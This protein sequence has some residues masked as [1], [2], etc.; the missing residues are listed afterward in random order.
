VFAALALYVISCA[1]DVLWQDSGMIQYRVWRNDIEGKL[2][3]AL[4]HPLFYVLAIGAKYVPIGQFAHK[5]NLVS[6][7]AAAVAV[8]NLFLF[9]RLWLGRALP[10]IVAAGTFAL[11]HTFWRHASIA[12]T[13]SLYIALFLAGLIML[14]QYVRTRRLS[15]LYG[16][17]LFN[18]LAIADHMFACIPL[19]CYAVYVLVLLMRKDIRFKHLAIFVLFWV[20]GAGLYEYLIIKSLVQTGDLGGTLASAAFGEAYRGDVLNIALSPRLLKENVLFILLNFPTPNIVLFFVG[21]F[22]LYRLSGGRAFSNVL[23]GVL[24]LFLL[25][26]CRYTVVDRY[27]FFIP[28]YCMVSIFVGLGAHHLLNR[29]RSRAFAIAVLLMMVLPIAAYAIAPVAAEKRG[30]SIGTKREIPYRNDYDYFLRPWR[31]GYR[32]ARR[33]A[34]EALDMVEKNAV[35]YCDGTTVY[36]LLCIQQAYGKRDDVQIVSARHSSENAPHL[37]ENTAADLVRNSALYVVSPV[38]GYCPTFLLERYDFVGQ[39][40]LWKVVER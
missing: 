29:A 1:P 22:A 12:E 11:S 3:L 13:Y 2:G 8:G 18:G 4:S 32:G 21:C 10:A 7:V 19:A 36:P 35:I 31:T 38:K 30:L 37:N 34:D 25:F 9:L 16:V 5:V 14:L 26:A 15:Y 20:V 6:A 28:F 27:A 39:G 17:A 24:I 23:L 33:F 40:L